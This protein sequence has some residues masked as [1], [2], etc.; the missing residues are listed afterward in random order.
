MLDSEPLKIYDV[1]LSIALSRFAIERPLLL[2]P[3]ADDNIQHAKG[4]SE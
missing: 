3:Y 2:P 4:A 1:D